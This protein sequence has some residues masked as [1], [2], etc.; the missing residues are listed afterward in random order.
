LTVVD[1]CDALDLEQAVPQ[2]AAHSGP[3]YMR[4][5]RGNVPLVLDEY[6][7]AF[8]LGK[9]KLL[10][11]G[12]D[13]L[14][15]SSG[16]MTMRALETVEQLRA[17]RIDVAVLH[18]PTIKP[19]DE[20]T[21]LREAGRSGRLVIVAENHAAIGGLGEAVATLLLRSGVTPVFKQIALP[22]Q[23]LG[24]GAL[25]TLH[26]LYGISTEAMV[27]TIKSWLAKD[28]GQSLKQ[29]ASSRA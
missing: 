26:D 17:D 4:L 12:Q 3:V 16:F 9:A 8:E 5:A 15:V 18:V 11:D 23:F 20:Q 24:A 21:I 28:T 6:D 27:G 22:D 14:L 10:R 2:I 29:Q 7:Y 13:A 1:P 25:P 19:L